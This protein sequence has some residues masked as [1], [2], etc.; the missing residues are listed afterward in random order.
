MKEKYHIPYT[1]DKHFG[2]AEVNNGKKSIGPDD[3]TLRPFLITMFSGLAFI[4]FALTETKT[5]QIFLEGSIWGDI[6]ITIGYAGIV[7]FS[8]R[9]I[10]V[11]GL[12][13]YNVISPFMNYILGGRNRKIKSGLEQ[14]YVP[15]SEFVGMR[16]PDKNGQL[17]FN[18][19]NTCARLFK[20]TGT[21]SNNSFSIDRQNTIDEFEIFLNE[22]PKDATIS[23]ITN[24]GGQNVDRQL[25][26][27]I[28]LADQ[29]TDS[30]INQYIVEE[31]NELAHYIQNNFVT[32]HQYMLIIGADEAA[33]KNAIK[34]VIEI[35]RRSNLVISSMA[36]PSK[37]ANYAFFKSIYGGIQIEKDVVERV[38]KFEA[39]NNKK[40]DL[41][42]AN[43]LVPDEDDEPQSVNNNAYGQKQQ[44][45]RR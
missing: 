4:Y 37:K 29:E 24:T 21:A 6:L 42:K 40:T 5:S 33:L 14:P 13:G 26:H 31:A 43:E 36:V 9:E 10:S 19:H 22:I 16:E 35:T 18:S 20:I 8:L 28:D 7:Y 12:Y 23:F 1:L 39:D 32:L 45:Q 2:D 30:Q 15:V 17:H 34:D 11:P 27:L 41:E 25:M 44:F 3:L 38:A